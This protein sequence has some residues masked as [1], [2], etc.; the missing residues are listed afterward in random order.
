MFW[1]STGHLVLKEFSSLMAINLVIL[2]FPLMLKRFGLHSLHRL[3]QSG[4]MIVNKS[5]DDLKVLYLAD[6]LVN[7]FKI[8]NRTQ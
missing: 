7:S 2:A 6:R 8:W 5:D 4:H 1:A 3:N